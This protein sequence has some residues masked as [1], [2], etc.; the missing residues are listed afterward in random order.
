MAAVSRP[1]ME[2]TNPLNPSP[3]SAPPPRRG[4]WS[5]NWKWFVPT[6]CLAFL[7]LVVGFAVL[8]GFLIFAGMKSTDVYKQALAR[9]KS[10][11]A[12]AA[13]LGTPLHEGWFLSGKTSVEGPTGEADIAIPVSGPK[14]AGTV[15]AVASK[16]AGRWTFSKLEL[17]VK[18]TGQRIDLAPRPAE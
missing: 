2:P 5:R 15:Y 12:V 18:E 14:G 13:A 8:I 4:W 16:S 7:V 1:R 6:G 17:E 10:D 3:L 9:A 11:P